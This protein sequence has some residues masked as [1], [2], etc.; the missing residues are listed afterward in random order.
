[1]RAFGNCISYNLVR[2]PKVAAAHRAWTSAA[3]F[4][5]AWPWAE[6]PGVERYI[7]DCA[8][9][10]SIEAECALLGLAKVLCSQV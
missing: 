3:L 7:K 4:A 1:M 6:H 10:A 5:A 8:F 9:W 2:W